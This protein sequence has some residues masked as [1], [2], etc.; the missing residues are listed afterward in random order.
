MCMCRNDFLG[1]LEPYM[2]QEK[3]LIMEFLRQHVSAFRTMPRGLV[4]NLA[5]HVQQASAA[6]SSPSSTELADS[7]CA[8]CRCLAHSVL[9]YGPA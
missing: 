8:S 9:D 7:A 3:K 2:E 6:G 5:Q 1:V 4:T